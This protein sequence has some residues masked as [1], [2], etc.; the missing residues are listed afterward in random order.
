MYYLLPHFVQKL[1]IYIYIYIYI[2]IYKIAVY[3]SGNQIYFQTRAGYF[4]GYHVQRILEY[5][6]ASTL[7]HKG[8]TFHAG[9]APTALAK[10][11]LLSRIE[12]KKHR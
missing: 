5:H 12:I 8:C 2:C 6:S 11:S 4:L 10:H 7:L 3:E 9:K 1:V